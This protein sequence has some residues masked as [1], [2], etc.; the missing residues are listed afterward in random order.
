M[1]VGF[2]VYDDQAHQTAPIIFVLRK[3]NLTPV[4]GVSFYNRIRKIRW[5]HDLSQCAFRKTA[6]G[7][8]TFLILILLLCVLP[9]LAIAQSQPDDFEKIFGKPRV[10][11]GQQISVPIFIE[12]L[13]AGEIKI[14][15]ADKAEDVMMEASS[16]L[17]GI[18]SSLQPDLFEQIK[19]SVDDQGNLSVQIL[20]N[21]GLDILFDEQKLEMRV[22]IPANLRCISSTQLFGR[23]MPPGA[24]NAL[25]TSAFSTYVNLR[26]GIDYVE[27]SASGRDEG[28]QRFRGDI[29]GA[30]NFRDWVL[31]GSVAYTQDAPSEWRRGDTRF[32]HDDPERM[33]RY[34][35]GDISYPTAG[36]QSFAPMLGVNLARNFSLQPYRVTEPRGQTTFFLKSRSKVE[37]FVNGQQV[38]TLQLS[39]GPQNLKDFLFANGGNDVT[40]RITDDVGRVETIQLSYF[41][42]T[43]LLAQGEQEFSYSVGLPSQLTDTGKDYSIESPTVSMFHRIGLTDQV[44]AG[45]NLQGN[46]RQ[47]LFGAETVWATPVGTF[48]PD[49]ALSQVEGVGFDYATRLG[50]RYYDATSARGSAW[51]V[52]AQYRGESF[53]SLGNLNPVNSVAW[54]FAARYSQRLPWRM[55]GGVGG[56]YQLS[57]NRQRDLNGLNLFLSKRFGRNSYADITFDRKTT[58]SGKTEYRAFASVTFMFPDHRQSV[59]SSYDTFTDTARTDWQYTAPHAVGGLDGNLGLQHRPDDYGAYGGMRYNGYRAETTLAHDI[60][61]PST[62]S[63]NTDSRTSLRFGTALVYADGQVAVSRPVR[64]SFAIVAPHPTLKGQDIGVDPIQNSYAARAGRLGPAVIPDLSSYLVRNVTIEAP[65]L[66]LG[67]ELGSG[68][69]TVQPTYK[70]GTVIGIG[71]GATVIL[72]G[73]VTTADGT[74]ISLQE[75]EIIS[76]N[77]PKIKP[78]A[79][80]TNKRGK[81]SVEGLKPGAYEMRLFI[82]PSNVLVFDIPKDAAGI[83]NIGILKF[84]RVAK[85]QLSTQ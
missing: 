65:D 16:L 39:A 64:D 3:T 76:V 38:Q 85:A 14:R 77:D 58:S 42:D 55:N 82:D 61:T 59:R 20:R 67:Y 1:S 10:V 51:T 44:T 11:A 32:V 13:S 31:E 46:S 21:A 72:E 78:V 60:T 7:K 17:K 9:V 26:S 30:M 81:F 73:I 49:V 33:L 4:V 63:G 70:S 66:P 52:S 34:S 45:L 56:N 36:F 75:G 53:A 18:E 74:P 27:R 79:L 5:T 29:E 40:L 28:L 69:Y 15:L 68:I 43:R 47:Q 80:F 62:S 6:S 35:L 57:R 8:L 50:Y 19:N 84:S 24:E 23:N 54:D 22:T 25:P 12:N 41:F 83:Y 37:V 2:W 71:T 48:Q